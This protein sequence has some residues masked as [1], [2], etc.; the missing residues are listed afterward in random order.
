[1]T[2]A[3]R[4]GCGRWG[5]VGVGAERWQGEGYRIPTPHNGG[6]IPVGPKFSSLEVIVG[7]I[8]PNSSGDN[9]PGG[10]G[11][12][13][14]PPL[15]RHF[16]FPGRPIVPPPLLPYPSTPYVQAPRGDAG[17]PP[18]PRG[19]PLFFIL[20]LVFERLWG[21]GV[22]SSLASGPTLASPF[23][24]SPGMDPGLPYGCGQRLPLPPLPLPRR[25]PMGRFE[26][27][28]CSE[29]ASF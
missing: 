15:C 22:L 24:R 11:V 3:S 5:G 7:L 27:A 18:S 16:A 4:P 17:D 9:F 28:K 1:M 20:E 19:R 26:S 14:P 29:E 8:R 2:G 10:W 23:I 13:S 21:E 12:S 6:G 25:D